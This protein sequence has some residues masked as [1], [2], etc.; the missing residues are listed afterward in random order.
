MPNWTWNRVACKKKLGD[1]LLTKTEKGFSLDFNKIIKMPEE[2][3]IESG[4][5]GQEG[6]MYL[7]VKSKNNFE[8]IEINNAYRELN[9]FFKDIYR[10][11]RFGSIEENIEKYDNDEEFKKSIE[12]GKKYLD[13]Y[14]KYGH[15]T[16]Y[17]WCVENWGTKWNVEDEVQ[18]EYDS[19][20]EEYIICFD[21]AW[22]PPRGI[23]KAFAD[24]CDKEEDFNWEYENEDYD[25]H[26]TLIL[27]NG[28]I[29]DDIL[30]EEE[31]NEEEQDSDIEGEVA[32]C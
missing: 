2:L 24:M 10:E 21:T 9:P 23:I 5:R 25:G 8:R 19:K 13:N 29:Y 4:S 12:L 28:V 3:D 16:W 32:L 17:N 18:V 15:C 11:N 20:N 22:D 7:Y 27:Q 31:N 6:L 1:K 30:D 26:H 14:K